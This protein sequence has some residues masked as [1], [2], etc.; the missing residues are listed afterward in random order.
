MR[1]VQLVEKRLGERVDAYFAARRQPVP[2]FQAMRDCKIIAHRGAHDN[3]RV[4]ENTIPAFEAAVRAGIWGLECDVRWTRDFH[5]VVFHDRTALR[6]FHSPMV[7]GEAPLARLR[8]ECPLIPTLDQVVQTCGR[9]IHLMVELKK[10]EFPDPAYQRAVLQGIF[11]QL[12]PVKDFHILALD[13]DILRL[14]DFV[15]REA[16]I[17]VAELNLLSQSRTA[18]AKGYGGVAGHYWL[19]VQTL[20]E[21][22]KRHGQKAG[23]GFIA[24]RNCLFREI[25]RGVEWIFS[26]C[27]VALQAMVSD[28]LRFQDPAF[29]PS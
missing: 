26:N 23:T 18:I 16:L 4:W 22:H 6:L 1:L 13:A 12:E 8:T 27:A 9:Q 17:L 20:L 28:C 2:P 14:V 25:N 21:K 10:E 29:R 3:C 11:S 19:F 24:S 7:L 5:P 15:P